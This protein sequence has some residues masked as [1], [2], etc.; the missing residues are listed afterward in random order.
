MQ[1]HLT[2]G[3]NVAEDLQ[4]LLDADDLAVVLS[5]Q[6][7]PRCIIEFISQCIQLL[8]LEETKR[9]ILVMIS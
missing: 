5:S 9:S 3:S 1:C 4:G 6:H 8:N 7:R 2:H